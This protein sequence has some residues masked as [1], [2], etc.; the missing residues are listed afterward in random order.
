MVEN[1]YEPKSKIW[2][3]VLA[4][5]VV[6]ILGG[7]GY[8][9][10]TWQKANEPPPS[11]ETEDGSGLQGLMK[12]G[13]GNEKIEGFAKFEEGDVTECRRNV[14]NIEGG[15]KTDYLYSP[16][17]ATFEDFYDSLA[18]KENVKRTFL[19]AFYSPG[20]KVGDTNYDKGFYLFPTE[21]TNYKAISVKIG[22]DLSKYKV[23]AYRTVIL[24]HDDVMGICADGK[25]VS[26]Y[27]DSGLASMDED[28]EGMVSMN[29]KLKSLPKGWVLVPFGWNYK[30]IEV[31]NNKLGDYVNS[32]WVKVGGKDAKKVNTGNKNLISAEVEVSGTRAV[33][34]NMKDVTD[35]MEKMKEKKDKGGDGGK[36][37]VAPSIST[38]VYSE[39]KDSGRIDVVF[40]EDF[41][42]YSLGSICEAKDI[43]SVEC[44]EGA[45]NLVNDGV[46]KIDDGGAKV[47]INLKGKLEKSFYVVSFDNLTD[48]AGN[49]AGHVAKAFDTTGA[50]AV[51]AVPGDV[52]GDGKLDCEKDNAVLVDMIMGKAA[53]TPCADVNGDG[54][55]DMSDIQKFVLSFCPP[56]LG[57]EKLTVVGSVA[58]DKCE[59]FDAKGGSVGVGFGKFKFTAGGD[60]DVNLSTIALKRDG[61]GGS[62]DDFSFV[63]MTID[64]KK[65]LGVCKNDTAIFDAIGKVVPKGESLEFDVKA[66]IAVG[67]KV[68]G[69]N[70]FGVWSVMYSY[71]DANGKKV[72]ATEKLD[73]I[74]YGCPVSTIAETSVAEAKSGEVCKVDA[75]CEAGLQCQNKGPTLGLVCSAPAEKP[76]A[77]TGGEAA[78]VSVDSAEEVCTDSRVATGNSAVVVHFDREVSYSDKSAGL[79]DGWVF[80]VGVKNSKI[81][82]GVLSVGYYGSGHVYDKSS[83]LIGL[84]GT[85]APNVDYTVTVSKSGLNIGY[86][87]AMP[88]TSCAANDAGFAVVGVKQVYPDGIKVTFNTA[89][90]AEKAKELTKYIELHEIDDISVPR[91]DS[92][93]TAT[94]PNEIVS[95]D[96][97]SGSAGKAILVKFANN[98]S[99]D[100]IYQF[101][102]TDVDSVKSVTGVSMEKMKSFANFKGEIPA[103][104]E[105]F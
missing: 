34:M 16:E 12:I 33:W 20:E 53:V 41:K 85:M 102:F 28:V 93:F 5:V 94:V 44:S 67:A 10:Y 76:G 13:A 104:G 49:V 91:V 90:D 17:E 42:S 2:L 52:D 51:C 105:L 7:T 86:G 8:G 87:N 88:I 103:G 40:S 9:Y 3:W 61:A 4:V 43:S 79:F 35:V 50:V 56:S 73:S 18:V 39:D 36:D 15:S 29:A 64:G 63:I 14:F 30:N 95:V 22:D 24:F 26:A 74:V 38:V 6:L 77:G 19:M 27:Y 98:L 1:L 32:I 66:D 58:E 47:I 101:Q 54:S 96:V 21:K 99:T 46:I 37:T 48:A 25:V 11:L 80:K 83:L 84:N 60:S 100:S 65:H 75:D 68:S 55:V 78:S 31:L 89:I 82:L 81:T 70:R 59:D 45:A 57:S 23:P 69:Q 71:L 97:V 92:G 62:C 72:E